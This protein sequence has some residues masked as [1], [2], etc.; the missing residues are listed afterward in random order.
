MTDIL[1]ENFSKPWQLL[2]C[3]ILVGQER[4]ICKNSRITGSLLLMF[5][6]VMFHCNDFIKTCIL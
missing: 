1:T 6:S 5:N 4:V 3:I 2:L